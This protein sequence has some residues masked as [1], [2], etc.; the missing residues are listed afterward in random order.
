MTDVNKSQRMRDYF[1]EHDGEVSISE[2]EDEVGIRYQF[3]YQVLRRHC[4]KNDIELPTTQNNGETKKDRMIEMWED[5]LSISEV[6]KEVD[7]N[8]SYAWSTIDE[9][10]KDKKQEDNEEA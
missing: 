1:N 2:V 9:H 4:R 10:R 5:G 8:Y 7:T 6:A 3:A